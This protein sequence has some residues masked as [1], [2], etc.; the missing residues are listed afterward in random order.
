MPKLKVNLIG[1]YL[2]FINVG[3]L[4]AS[5]IGPTR[6]MDIEVI[7]RVSRFMRQ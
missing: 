4:I 7:A 6:L 3:Y 5:S 2:L 1:F